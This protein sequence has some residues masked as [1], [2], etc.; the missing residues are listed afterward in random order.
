MVLDFSGSIQFV[1]VETWTSEA[2]S[3]IKNRLW[4]NPGTSNGH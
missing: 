4:C 1:R 2:R 3:S